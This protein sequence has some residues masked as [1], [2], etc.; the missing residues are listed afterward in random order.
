[1]VLFLARLAGTAKELRQGGESDEDINDFYDRRHAAENNFYDILVQ[2]SDDAPVERADDH[3]P[4]ADLVH[5]TALHHMGVC[6][7]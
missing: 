6:Y 3:E 5:R 4:I 2:K 1:M 7:E